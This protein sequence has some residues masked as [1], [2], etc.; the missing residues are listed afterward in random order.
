LAGVGPG[1]GEGQP[2]NPII[3]PILPCLQLQI[4]E[5]R[6]IGDWSRWR[7]AAT[8]SPDQEPPLP[9]LSLPMAVCVPVLWDCKEAYVQVGSKEVYI[10]VGKYRGVRSPFHTHGCIWDIQETYVYMGFLEGPCT[11]RGSCDFRVCLGYQ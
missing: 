8:R 5:H 1:L 3:P 2:Y 7:G 6:C 10:Y 9:Q 4:Q 11:C